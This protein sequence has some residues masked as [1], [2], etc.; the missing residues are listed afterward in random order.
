MQAVPV[1]ARRIFFESSFEYFMP[2]SNVY[3][4]FIDN[5][6]AGGKQ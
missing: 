6:F 3:A 5:Y 4:Y 1:A 2:F